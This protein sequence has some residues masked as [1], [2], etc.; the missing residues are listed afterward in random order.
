MAGHSLPEAGH[1]YGLRWSHWP[2]LS[3]SQ[4]L[5][6]KEL[7]VLVN[8]DGSVPFLVSWEWAREGGQPGC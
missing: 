7:V 2:S 8:T 6:G 1:L 3:Q 4:R 5:Q